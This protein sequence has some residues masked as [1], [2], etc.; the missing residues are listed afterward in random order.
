MSFDLVLIFFQI[1]GGRGPD[2]R[3]PWIR[4]CN[5]W[6]PSPLSPKN[7]PYLHSIFPTLSNYHHAIWQRSNNT[8]RLIY[9]SKHQIHKKSNKFH[10]IIASMLNY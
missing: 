9:I 7:V 10:I 5:L 3:T 2:P 6:T 4:Y 1:L 8:Y